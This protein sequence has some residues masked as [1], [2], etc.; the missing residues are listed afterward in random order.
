[1][2]KTNAKKTAKRSVTKTP[3]KDRVKAVKAKTMAAGPAAKSAKR[4]QKTA[5]KASPSKGK[6]RTMIGR[7][8]AK[9]T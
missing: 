2:K 4:T 1:M 8:I 5:A 3:A 6:P 9:L 7:L